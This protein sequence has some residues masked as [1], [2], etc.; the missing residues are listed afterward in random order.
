M[1]KRL[2]VLLAVLLVGCT[3]IT[4]TATPEP[5]VNGPAATPVLIY[6]TPPPTP[7]IIY[8]TP[9]PATPSPAPTPRPTPTP[10]KEPT[11]VPTA[12]PIVDTGGYDDFLSYLTSQDGKINTTVKS[13]NTRAPSTW[14]A[15][16]DELAAEGNDGMAWINDHPADDCYA[17]LSNAEFF[18]FSDAALVGIDLMINSDTL[19]KD[20]KTWKHDSKAAV[21]AFDTVY[22]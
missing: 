16:G 18:Y 15:T 20:T 6:V 8:V 11:P 19:L 12:V 10:T 1:V 22:C 17:E 4:P 14:Y 13:W 21:K 5:T 2:V 7:L 9:F 3:S